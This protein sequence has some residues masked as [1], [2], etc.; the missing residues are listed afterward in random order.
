MVARRAIRQWLLGL[1]LLASFLASENLARADSDNKRKV[2]VLEYRSGSSALPD[3]GARLATILRK[4]TSLQVIDVD[5][6]RRVQGRDID[7]RVAKCTGD[8]GCIA[9][10]GQALDA[11][12]VLLIGVSRFGDEI[13]TLQRIDASGAKVLTRIADVVARG[14]EPDD[15]A[16]LSYLRKVLP[17]QDF[18]R[19]G[20]IRVESDIADATVHVNGE[21]SGRTPLKPL[22]VRAP[23]SYEIRIEKAGYTPFTA[24]VEVP[25]DGEVKV[26]TPLARRVSTP[27][28]K[29][30]WVV[31]LAG[32]AVVGTV[33]AFAFTGD[34]PPDLPVTIR[35]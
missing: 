19:Y 27:W 17:K 22:R 16:L 18:L 13:I 4:K 2:A 25:P 23:A 15:A 11:R 29:R 20:T 24:T 6:A 5:D 21:V 10:I 35:F 26:T 7:R 1:A 31:A 12:E 28:Y 9:T 33:S 34:A 14:E 30:W 3:V 32:G 8:A